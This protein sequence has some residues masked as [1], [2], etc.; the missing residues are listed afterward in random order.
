MIQS[1]E[2][3]VPCKNSNLV[4]FTR[5]DGKPFAAHEIKADTSSI[6]VSFEEKRTVWI[7]VKSEIKT[8]EA[9]NKS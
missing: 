4:N 2:S 9:V 5:T 1:S 7:G 6:E 8:G 3:K